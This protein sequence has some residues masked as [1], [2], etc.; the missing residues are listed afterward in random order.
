MPLA[1]ICALAV[2]ELA[3]PDALLFLWAPAP[4]LEEAFQVIGAWGFEYRT[5]MVWAKDKIGMG[6]YVRQ[7]HEHLLIARR[8]EIPLPPTDARPPSL[9]HAARGGHS[10][11]PVEMYGI[12]ERMYPELPKI[13]LFARQAREGWSFWGNEIE[14]TAVG[15]A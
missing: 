15:A 14:T 13:E 1:E 4:K 5:G 8:G 9:L 3:T 11:K 2:A 10:E 6:N 7:Q 12:I